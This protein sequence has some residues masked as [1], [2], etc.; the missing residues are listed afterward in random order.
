MTIELRIVTP[1]PMTQRSPITLFSMIE[2]FPILHPS[3]TKE[4]RIVEPSMTV[5]GKKRGLV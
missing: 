2:P 5:G 1:S 4:E 3:A